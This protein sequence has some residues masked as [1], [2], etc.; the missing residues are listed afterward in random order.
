MEAKLCRYEKAV[1]KSLKLLN[2]LNGWMHL[3]SGQLRNEGTAIQIRKTAGKAAF[4]SN[5]PKVCKKQE[6]GGLFGYLE[7]RTD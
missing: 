7:P 3:K 6:W 4:D 5:Q 1:R 2:S